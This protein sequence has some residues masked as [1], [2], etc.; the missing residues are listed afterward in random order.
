MTRTG[1]KPQASRRPLPSTGAVGSPGVLLDAWSRRWCKVP[2]GLGAG[3]PLV[4]HPFQQGVVDALWCDGVQVACWICGRGNA[5]STTSAV[6]GLHHITEGPPGA[7]G[8]I[9]SVDERSATRMLRTATR[10][11]EASASLSKRV[12]PYADRLVCARTGGEL[13]IVPAEKKRVEG[14]DLSLLIADEVGWMDADVWE[15]GLLSLK[16][17]GARALAVGTPSTAEWRDRAPLWGLVRAGR[18]GLDET[19][20]LVEFT[21]NLTHPLDCRCCWESANPGLDLVLPAEQLAASLRKVRPSEFARARLGRWLD[22]DTADEFLPPGAWAACAEVGPVSDGADVVLALDG[23][24]S[25]DCTA[26]VVCTISPRPHVDVA[27]LWL[28]PEAD[29][30]WRVPI[31]EVEAAVAAA[32]KRWRV[33]EVCADPFRWQRSLEVLAAQGLPVAEFPQS[34]QRMSP[35]TTGLRE[36]VINHQ[37]THSGNADLA[38]H[39]TNARLRDDARGVRIT[40]PS[41]HSRRRIDLAVAAVMA[42]ARATHYAHAPA[43]RSRRLVLR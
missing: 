26:L 41:K 9:V 40:K 33:R 5:K 11:V 39:V 37:V 3:G 43:R 13:V 32:C 19:L 16:A 42:H 18:L 34:Q 28:A 6:V 15:S 35:A 12:T 7:A 38:A 25:Q 4:L 23:S 14:L 8:A 24:F 2:R 30:E 21:S 36:A 17:P 1:P 29:P 31:L 10:I 20:A 22:G 27:G